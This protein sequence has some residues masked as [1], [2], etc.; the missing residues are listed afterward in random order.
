MKILDIPQSGRCGTFVSYRSRF[1][2]CRRALVVPKNTLTAA[3]ERA[4]RDFAYYARA[5]AAML[6]E[7]QRDAWN[8]AGPKVQSEKRLGQSGPL[9]GQ[10]HFQGI[11]SARACIGRGML[12][13]PP[14]PVV[15]DPNP[16]RQLVITNDA[17]GVRLFLKV[18]G[19]GTADIMVFGQAPC[20]RGR[21]KRRNVSYLGLPPA[22]EGGLIEITAL[23][24]ARFGQ[25]PPLTRVFIVTRQQ[26]DGWQDHDLVTNAVVP[27]NPA[28]QQA[29][30]ASPLSLNP[31]M[32]KG[33]TPGAQGVATGQEVGSP[34][35]AEPVVPGGEAGLP[36]QMA[37]GREAKEAAVPSGRAAEEGV[38]AGGDEAP[39]L[40]KAQEPGGSP[41]AVRNPPARS[42][43]A[44]SQPSES[45]TPGNPS[46]LEDGAPAVRGQDGADKL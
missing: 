28:G 37:D 2:Q 35:G 13:L 21:S 7:E 14:E 8:L 44:G 5:W 29:A 10:Q 45:S 23:Y 32:H 18:S 31:Y 33:C 36:G 27:E 3:R 41:E 30:T 20:S 15:F 17:N 46:R 25:P 9:T 4:R 6:T 38:G 39:A 12:L 42:F 24:V 34:Q 40:E 19:P 16:V 43:A 1:G 26:K 22:P 11:S